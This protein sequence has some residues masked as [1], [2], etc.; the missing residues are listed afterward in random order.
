MAVPSIDIT[1]PVLNE[2]RCLERSVAALATRLDAECPYTWSITVVD[3]GSTD[4]TWGIAEGIAAED[5]RVR[6]IRLDRRGRGRALKKAW[7]TSDADVVA[8][9]DVDLSTGLESLRG[10]IDP[11]V[12]G[13]ADVSIG[14]RLAQGAQIQRS[15]R[16]EVISRIYNFITRAVF[17]Y[18][19]LDAQ[20]GF[21]AARSEVARSL[22]PLIEDDGWFLSLI[23][24]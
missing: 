9:M 10:L 15:A 2:E 7:A 18:S 6:A 14:S 16:R 22:I 21:K 4:G 24:I 20:C 8:Y 19:V 13:T 1:I 5:P 23:H 12:D 11:L 17:R 3:N